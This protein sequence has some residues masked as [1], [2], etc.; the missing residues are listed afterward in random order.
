MPFPARSSAASLAPART[1]PNRRAAPSFAI[2]RLHPPETALLTA[3]L[4]RLDTETRRLRF[5]NPVNDAFLERYGEL[6]LGHDAVVSGCFTK[7][8]LRGVAE[9]RFLDGRRREAE[10]AFSLEPDFQGMGL[11]DALFSRTIAM[12][13]N[14][15]V[16][17]LY[18]TCLSENRRMQRIAQRHGAEISFAAGDVMADIRRPYA[19]PESIAEENTGERDAFVVALL[20]WR[21]RFGVLGRSVRRL[22]GRAK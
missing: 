6:A 22:A 9:L 20:E 17:R 19:D 11:G 5:G 4:L 18:L 15:G 14:R 10:G 7:G 1:P 13:R 8:T 12:A 21:Q 3:H 2:R 16:Q